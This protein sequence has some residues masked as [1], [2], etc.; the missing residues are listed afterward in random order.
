MNSNIQILVVEDDIPV[1]N[2]ITTTLKA[3]G[4]RFLVSQT[5]EGAVM[6]TASHNPDIILLDLG[7]P[8]IDGVEV[9]RK[10][11]TWSNV[12][13][14]VISARS[15]DADKIDA[16]DAGADDYLTKPFSVDELLA[17][18]RVTQ[19]RLVLMQ[20]ST[21]EPQSVFVNGQLRIDYAAGCASLGEEELHLT[22]IEYKLLCLLARNIGK[23]LTH[24]F[25]TQSVWGSS[26]E[27]DV[28]SLRVFM[29]TLRKKLESGENSPQYIQT[30][31]GIGYR[32][33]KV[34]V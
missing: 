11:R 26:W 25:I 27:N 33:L 8:D 22:P 31:I 14:L 9:I 30:H 4:Y 3:Q 19:R 17:R 16:L 5:G 28:V 23:V 29:A 6:E 10:I 13:I 2:L 21:L 15:E 12:P 32:M 7:L 1:Q 20:Q 18:L 24:K 34:D